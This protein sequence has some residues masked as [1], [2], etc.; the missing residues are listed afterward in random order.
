MCWAVNC[1]RKPFS[2]VCL[3]H[4]NSQKFKYTSGC[5]VYT[6]VNPFH[7]VFFTWFLWVLFLG[8]SVVI[9]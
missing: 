1:I 4:T 9:R 6:I 2:S 5:I 8:I 3:M 7:F